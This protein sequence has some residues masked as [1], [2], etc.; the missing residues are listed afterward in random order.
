MTTEVSHQQEES[1]HVLV[2][3][4]WLRDMTARLDEVAQRF[5]AACDRLESMLRKAL[6]QQ[7]GT[8]A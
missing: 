8:D 3:L 1:L 6:A 2:E 4:Q 7:G 5:E